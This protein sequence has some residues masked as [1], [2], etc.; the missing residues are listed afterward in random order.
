MKRLVKP[1][2]QW[3][4][5][6]ASLVGLDVSAC[7]YMMFL[8]VVNIPM[9]FLMRSLPFGMARILFGLIVGLFYCFYTFGS[10][11]LHSVAIPLIVYVWLFLTVGMSSSVREYLKKSRL[12]LIVPLFAFFFSFGYLLI[13]HYNRMITDYLGWK[14]DFT[15]LQMLATL[16][17]ISVAWNIYDGMIAQSD[18]KMN[19][20]HKV[21]RMERMPGLLEYFSYMFFFPSILTGPIYEISDYLR[22]IYGEFDEDISF[23]NKMELKPNRQNPPIHWKKIFTN[24]LIAMVNMVL[25]LKALPIFDRPQLEDVIYDR[26][27]DQ[28]LFGSSLLY[29]LAFSWA[30]MVA[31]KFKYIVG[32]CWSESAMI[33]CGMGYQ[34]D[35]KTDQYSYAGCESIEYLNHLLSSNLRDI[36]T[37]WNVSV[38]KW[39][40]NYVYSRVGSGAGTKNTIITFLVS[41]SWHGLYSGYYVMWTNY[42][43]CLHFIGR[44]AHKKVRPLFLND[45]ENTFSEK[46]SKFMSIFYKTL[47][48]IGTNIFTSYLLPPFLLLSWDSSIQFFSS[49]RWIGHLL[50][51]PIYVFLTLIPS[52]GKH[53]KKE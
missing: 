50:F 25:T 13:C 19:Y 18:E 27:G 8:I 7:T 32:W 14:L 28:Q 23:L 29:K 52:T 20:Y 12:G 39:L 26:V 5:K 1:V 40:R 11:T 35:R 34:K 49:M 16:K 22:M 36:T 2:D 4:E 30:C 6:A 53:Q 15:G 51:I 45:V 33:I 24:L 43:I 37:T 46:N 10:A 42:A 44:M 3:M 47:S 9:A 17:T 41:A 21:N 38:S 48:F 31:I